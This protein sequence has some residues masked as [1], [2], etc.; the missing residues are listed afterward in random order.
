MQSKRDKE[1]S[2][3]C[4]SDRVTAFYCASGVFV[5][6]SAYVNLRAIPILVQDL[7]LLIDIRS[8]LLCSAMRL[9]FP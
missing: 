4:V 2:P 9:V 5:E 6:G 1:K 3:T 8:A 7:T